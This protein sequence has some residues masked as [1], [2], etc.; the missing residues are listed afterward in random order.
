MQELLTDIKKALAVDY[1]DTPAME[2]EDCMHFHN[3]YELVLGVRAQN[4]CFLHDTGYPFTDRTLIFIPAQ[5][6]HIIRYKKGEPYARYV[7]IFSRSY[8]QEALEALGGPHLLEELCA[9]RCLCV[10]LSH[11][12][13]FAVHG[14]FQALHRSSLHTAARSETRCRLC[15][16]LMETARL[17]RECAGHSPQGVSA[18]DRLVRN[19]VRWLD[20]NYA[21]PVTLDALAARFFVSK[22]YLCHIFQQVTGTGVVD[23]LQCRRILEAQKLLMQGGCSNQQIAAQCGFRNMQ[24]FYRVFRRVAG[25]PPG[26]YRM[27]EE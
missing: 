9:Q 6:V 18:P 10:Q 20:E 22:Y 12:Q 15:L 7:V 26:R 14:L 24:H 19:V 16:L 25:S 23:Y 13:Y 3:G 1:S 17:L 8:V 11:Q 2:R 27:P 4:E 5:L 21:Q